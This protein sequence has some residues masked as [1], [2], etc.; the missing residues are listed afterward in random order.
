MTCCRCGYACAKTV[1]FRD[2]FGVQIG[3]PVAASD[4][5]VTAWPGRIRRGGFASS[6]G[7]ARGGF[8]PPPN[9]PLSA[10]RFRTR[11]RLPTPDSQARQFLR[12]SSLRSCFPSWCWASASRCGNSWVRVNDIRLCQDRRRRCSGQ[13]VSDGAV[14]IPRGHFADYAPKDTSPPRSAAI[15]LALLFNQSG[16]GWNIRCCLCDHSARSRL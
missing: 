4:R 8:V 9:M 2:A 14:A 5:E 15:A 10:A 3:L 6:V 1:V 13:L 11:W 16:N 7:A 12:C